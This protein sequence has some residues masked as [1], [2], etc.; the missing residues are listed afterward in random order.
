M[1]DA[2]VKN[3]QQFVMNT[4]IANHFF[5]EMIAEQN[6]IIKKA[7]TQGWGL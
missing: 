3:L 2:A 6:G 7:P 4:A 1:F 5:N